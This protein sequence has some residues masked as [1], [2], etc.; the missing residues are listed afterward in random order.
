[1]HEFAN[2]NNFHTSNKNTAQG[3]FYAEAY[4]GF[5]ERFDIPASYLDTV[6]ASAYSQHFYTHDE[7]AQFLQ[8]WQR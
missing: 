8:R 7:I 4:K 6:Y 2:L 1:M 5:L 3:K